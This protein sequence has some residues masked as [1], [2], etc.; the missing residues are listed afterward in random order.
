M[1][2]K[3]ELLNLLK[4]REKEMEM[5]ENHVGPE[6]R[7]RIWRLLH[8]RAKYFN[9]CFL[10]LFK[11]FWEKE[12][13][14]FFNK[15]LYVLIPDIIT[16]PLYLFGFIN[17]EECKLTRFLIKNLKEDDIFF[18]VGANYG[19]YS[20]LAAE[21][22]KEENIHLFEPNNRIFSCLTKTFKGREVNLNEIALSDK[23]GK[24]KFYDSSISFD[25]GESTI[26]EDLSKKA[27]LKII[28][29]DK[30]DN[31]CSRNDVIPDFIK[32][33]IEGSEYRAIEGGKR[34]LRE[35]SPIISSE[36]LREK[37]GQ[38]YSKKAISKLY[39]LGYKSYKITNQG[40]LKL[41]E[42][43]DPEMDIEGSGDNFIFKK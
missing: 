34:I 13:K 37:K 41:I 33:D 5:Y 31:Y 36:I 26:I 6:T 1:N 42:N 30:L 38:K 18:D 35:H 32:L 19:F 22:I 17:V 15:K 16:T 10:K 12:V 21:I 40:E 39:E 2:K 8:Y 27:E 23:I 11:S 28:N 25:G 9:I 43:L 24:I 4:E 7:N 20:L 29:S 14:T 3:E